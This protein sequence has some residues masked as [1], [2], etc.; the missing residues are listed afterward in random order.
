MANPIQETPLQ[1]ASIDTDGFKVEE[2]AYINKINLRGD[3]ESPAC[4]AALTELVGVGSELKPNTYVSNN[5]NTLFWL[6]PNE[7]LLYAEAEPDS[8]IERWC[9]TS[10]TAAVDLSD[11]YTV[12]KV[13]GSKVRDVVAS[14]SPFDVHLSRFGVGQCTQTR[15]G[16]ATILLSNHAEPP[17]FQLQVRWSYAKYVFGYLERVANYV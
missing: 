6:G 16:S 17:V 1:I 12:L 11:Y 5:T 2:L 9:S 10:G 7:R 4:N 14:G 3:F 8:V 15:F 13:S